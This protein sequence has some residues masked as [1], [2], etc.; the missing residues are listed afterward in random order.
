MKLLSKKIVSVLL[1][2]CSSLAFSNGLQ[3]ANMLFEQRGDDYGSQSQ[4]QLAK[5][6]REA[7]IQSLRSGLSMEDQ[8]I[9]WKRL[10]QLYLLEDSLLEANDANARK[11]IF[12]ECEDLVEQISP[13]KNRELSKNYYYMRGSCS[14]LYAQKGSLLDKLIR[15]SVFTGQKGKSKSLIDQAYD[16]GAENYFG[17]GI[18]RVYAGVYM[19]PSAK[20]V[21]FYKPEMALEYIR[22]AFDI[23]SDDQGLSGNDYCENHHFLM[24]TLLL[25]PNNMKAEAKE[26]AQNAIKHFESTID[27]N[28]VVSIGK[29]I[30]LLKVETPLCM[31]KIYNLLGTI[32]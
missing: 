30:P 17:G 11:A 5:K 24:K 4:G 18:Y 9:A 10:A 2:S 32:K 28:G 8:D 13:N 16:A 7:Y 1:F 31:K 3:T 14:G 20:A 22:K 26:A 21:N 6:A 19:D 23:D 15:I 12:K 29:N 27:T 25:Q